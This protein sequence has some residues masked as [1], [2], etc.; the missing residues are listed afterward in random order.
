MKIAKT[1]PVTGVIASVLALMLSTTTSAHVV[2]TPKQVLT[3]ERVTFTVSVPIVHDTPVS[4]GW[5]MIPVGLCWERPGGWSKA[6]FS[7][8][9]SSWARCRGG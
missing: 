8:W 4:E 2:V 9:S 5:L 6:S 3:G 7:P 1:L